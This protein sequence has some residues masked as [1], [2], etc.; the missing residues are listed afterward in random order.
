MRIPTLLAAGDF[1]PDDLGGMPAHHAIGHAGRSLGEF[2]AALDG[3]TEDAESLRRVRSAQQAVMDATTHEVVVDTADGP[4][5][6]VWVERSTELERVERYLIVRQTMHGRQAVLSLQQI[7]LSLSDFRAAG[8]QSWE[9]AIRSVEAFDQ[10]FPGLKYVRDSI[11]HANERAADKATYRGRTLPLAIIESPMRWSTLLSSHGYCDEDE[12]V[13][14]I[15]AGDR[16]DIA[17][18]SI[19]DCSLSAA[20]SI[21][22][23]L[24]DAIP[25]RHAFAVPQQFRPPL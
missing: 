22:Q 11:A 21:L 5:T 10:S 17:R 4:K 2:A 14:R 8:N 3:F 9:P 25:W 12:F 15:L 7:H 19:S 24:I 18:V 6:E 20:T 1:M 13:M 16:G 23:Q